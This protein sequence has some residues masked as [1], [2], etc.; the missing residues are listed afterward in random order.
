MTCGIKWKL[1][2]S[3]EFV[4][5]FTVYLSCDY[6][7]SMHHHDFNNVL[8]AISAYCLQYKFEYCIIGG[9]FNTYIS[10]VN[11]MNITSLH[12]F[13]SGD[14]LMFCMK[15]ENCINI[16]DTYCGPNQ[17]ISV[18]YHFII[19]SCLSSSID[20]YKTISSVSNISDQVPVFLDVECPSPK[21]TNISDTSTYHTNSIMGTCHPGTNRTVSV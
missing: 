4:H 7:I 11:S 18:I 16:D 3:D 12:N 15:S 14:C 20:V 5:L 1:N 21:S 10:R 6:N 17:S 13:G 9:D 2:N 8:S 19:S